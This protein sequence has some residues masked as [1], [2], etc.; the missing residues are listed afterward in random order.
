MTDEGQVEN[1]K[2][3][4]KGKERGGIKNYEVGSIRKACFADGRILG[5]L[6]PPGQQR[7]TFA[8][9]ATAEWRKLSQTASSRC[10]WSKHPE[11]VW[12]QALRPVAVSRSQ[13]R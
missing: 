12:V 1:E 7:S 13:S 2:G 6:P 4:L 10:F 9:A 5:L 8:A 3:E 11:N